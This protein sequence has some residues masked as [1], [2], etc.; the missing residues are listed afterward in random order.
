LNLRFYTFQGA[1]I[2]IETGKFLLSFTKKEKS[3]FLKKEEELAKN[4]NWNLL[5]GE[6]FF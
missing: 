2:A 6:E 4:R 3:E 1:L 5:N